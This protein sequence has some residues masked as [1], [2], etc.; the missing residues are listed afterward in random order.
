MAL[1]CG[2]AQNHA[3]TSH[4]LLARPH[5]RLAQSPTAR[6]APGPSSPGAKGPPMLSHIQDALNVY[7]FPFTIAIPIA[8]VLYLLA[9]RRDDTPPSAAEPAPTERQRPRVTT[10]AAAADT[11]A[12][13]VSQQTLA[14]RSLPNPGAAAARA[15]GGPA[16]GRTEP[17]PHARARAGVRQ[18]SP[19]CRRS[20]VRPHLPL[21]ARPADDAQPSRSLPVLAGTGRRGDLAAEARTQRRLARMLRSSPVRSGPFRSPTA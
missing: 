7:L 17:R 3:Q 18:P 21:T 5:A 15:T 14:R 20:Q 12:G 9:T 2:M 16:A 4:R 10:P 8:I 13:P 6:T 11:P 19:S 1:G